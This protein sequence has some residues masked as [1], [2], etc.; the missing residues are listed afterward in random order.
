MR[1][2]VMAHSIA[3]EVDVEDRIKEVLERFVSQRFN[4]IG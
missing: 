4:G 3:G 2:G 1:C